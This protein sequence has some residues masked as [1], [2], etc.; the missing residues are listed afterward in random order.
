MNRQ[1][2]LLAFAIPALMLF[3]AAAWMVLGGHHPRGADQAS[4]ITM[5]GTTL[6]STKIMLPGDEP[7][8]PG[9]AASDII[10]NNCTACHSVEMI[11]MQPPLDA[12]GWT[13][14]ITKMRSVFHA[15]IDPQDDAAITKALLALPTQ[16]KK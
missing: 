13:T 1:L 9:G 8:L 3:A 12:K 14:E 7:V 15:A 6:K 16:Q 5:G 4:A 11:E 2:G 10:T